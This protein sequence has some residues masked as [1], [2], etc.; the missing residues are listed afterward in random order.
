[1]TNRSPARVGRP[2]V[3]TTDVAK[4]YNGAI[5]AGANLREAAHVAGISPRTVQLWRNRLVDTYGTLEDAVDTPDDQLPD[6]DTTEPTLR[7]LIL[8]FRDI[9]RAQSVAIADRLRRI[10]QAGEQGMWT[11]DAWW[12]ERNF[13]DRYGRRQRIDHAG[14][15]DEPVEISIRFDGREDNDII[16]VE[17]TESDAG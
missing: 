14:V 3:L 16:D 13:P 7:S 17:A 10:R 5:I 1:M 8:F 9:E 12:L 6:D 15:P 2:T 11:A 4:A